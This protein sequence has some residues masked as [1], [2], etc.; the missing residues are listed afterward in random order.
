[1]LFVDQ[2]GPAVYNSELVTGAPG[3]GIY[4]VY[5]DASKDVIL[6]KYDGA[7]WGTQVAMTG[8]GVAFF[9]AAEDPTGV[10]HLAYVDTDGNCKYRYARSTANN[11]FTNP[12]VLG[13]SSS[14][15]FDSRLAV[16]SAGNGFVVWR[17]TDNNGKVLPIAPGEGP[18]L[19]IDMPGDTVK[20]DPDTDI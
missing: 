14:S 12:Q 19:G 6:R 17:D 2:S 4:L 11:D 10:V 16:N 7:N 15:Y 13:D 9:A 8:P 1:P 20:L 18:G 3:T 5:S